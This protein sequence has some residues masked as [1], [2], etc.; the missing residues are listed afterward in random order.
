MRDYTVS[1]RR[2]VYIVRIQKERPAKGQGR[3][4]WGWLL[5]RLGLA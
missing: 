3:S 2:L 5:A 4:W 1:S